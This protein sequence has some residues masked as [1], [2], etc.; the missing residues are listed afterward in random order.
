MASFG[1]PGERDEFCERTA[2]YNGTTKILC[3]TINAIIIW[4]IIVAY[5]NKNTIQNERD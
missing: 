4:Y 1:D 5:I 3:S 2:T